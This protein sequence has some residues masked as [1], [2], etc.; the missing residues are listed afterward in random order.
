MKKKDWLIVA[1]APFAVLLIPLVGNWV[2]EGWNWS[3]GDFVFAWVVFAV[4]TFIY[5]LLATR[6]FA[7]LAYKAGAALAIL[8]G[9]LVFWFTAA[10]QI[11]GEENSANLLYMVMLLLGLVG[12]GVAR[13][14]PAGMANA[15]FAMAAAT[16]LVPVIAFIFW[17]ADFSPGVAKVFI[18]NGVFVLMFIVFASFFRHAARR[19]SLS[20][21]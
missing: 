3:P 18:L 16:L 13:F 7:N 6:R 9:F 2:V 14:R 1:F 8:A 17:P 10:V 11:I 4:V 5:R 15:A 21:T 20:K 19:A 12:V